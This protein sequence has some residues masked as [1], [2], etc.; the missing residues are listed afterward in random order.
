LGAIR[1]RLDTA[2]R[3]WGFSGCG[4]D[5]LAVANFYVFLLKRL[6]LTTASPLVFVTKTF[7]RGS[8]DAAISLGI[9]AKLVRNSEITGNFHRCK[10]FLIF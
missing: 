8:R 6:T 2:A 1:F 9:S 7:F 5:A 10:I 3:G 4:L